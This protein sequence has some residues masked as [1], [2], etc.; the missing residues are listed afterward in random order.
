MKSTLKHIRIYIMRMLRKLAL[1]LSYLKKWSGNKESFGKCQ[2]NFCNDKAKEAHSI[3]FTVNYK[4]ACY[5]HSEEYWKQRDLIY[6]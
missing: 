1:R 5:E 6:A 4:A 2:H 3:P